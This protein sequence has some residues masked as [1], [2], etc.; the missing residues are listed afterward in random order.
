MSFIIFQLQGY[1]L[2]DK[3]KYS[4]KKRKYS[5]KAVLTASRNRPYG[6]LVGPREIALYQLSSRVVS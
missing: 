4:K 1:N 6:A 3:K 2:Y 5:K